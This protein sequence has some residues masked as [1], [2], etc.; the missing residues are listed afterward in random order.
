M[1]QVS[2]CAFVSTSGGAI[3]LATLCHQTTN[4][5]VSQLCGCQ[6]DRDLERRF[7]SSSETGFQPPPAGWAVREKIHRKHQHDTKTVEGSGDG[8]RGRADPQGQTRAAMTQVGKGHPRRPSGGTWAPRC[9]A[10]LAP[11]PLHSPAGR[12]HLR[13]SANSSVRSRKQHWLLDAPSRAFMRESLARTP[14]GYGSGGGL[15]S[16]RS[17][18]TRAVY[19]LV[20]SAAAAW[21][22]A[23]G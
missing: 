4:A 23:A 8:G 6:I 15:K 14:R 20:V 3:G 16:A 17:L 2:V 1:N 9:P 7:S 22:P 13:G 19:F 18:T 11:R 12:R 5:D 21:L 10:P